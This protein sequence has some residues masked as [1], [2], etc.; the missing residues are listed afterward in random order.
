[1][2]LRDYFAA[3]SIGQL[4]TEQSVLEAAQDA[5]QPISH[6]VAS[7]AYD[8]ADAMLKVREVKP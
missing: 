7:I 5:N 4:I 6:V 3:A 2:T 8:I 1:M